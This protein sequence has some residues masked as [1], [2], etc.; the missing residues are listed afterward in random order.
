MNQA[1]P[2]MVHGARIALL[3]I[4]RARRPDL[5]WDVRELDLAERTDGSDALGSIRWLISPDR[6]ETR[7]P[8]FR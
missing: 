3:S 2:D 1:P 5:S 6:P 4:L 7:L 8:E